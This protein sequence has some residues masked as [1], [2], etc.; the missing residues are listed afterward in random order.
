M[1]GY[2]GARLWRRKAAAR[3]PQF[4]TSAPSGNAIAVS[5][6][7]PVTIVGYFDSMTDAERAVRDLVNSGY[8][9]D[10]IGVVTQHVTPSDAP[11][12]SPNG[13]PRAKRATAR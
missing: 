12:A 2:A 3:L 13:L 6:G 1:W 8:P 5:L 9:Q 7:M 10:T 4:K 11:L